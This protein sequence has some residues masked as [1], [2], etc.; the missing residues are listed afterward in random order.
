DFYGGDIK[1]IARWAYNVNSLIVS[2]PHYAALKQEYGSVMQQFDP[3]TLSENDLT[4]IFKYVEGFG[5]ET[6]KGGPK[7]EAPET[8]QNAVIFGVI[9][10]ILAVIAL[11]LMQVNSN[12]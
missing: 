8:N 7:E 9:S 5:E 3:S 2:D 12:L 11:I 4:A 1:K 6:T 10:L